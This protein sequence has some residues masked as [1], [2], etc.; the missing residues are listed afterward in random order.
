MYEYDFVSRSTGEHTLVIAR[1]YQE[2][3]Y[4]GNVDTVD[5]ELWYQEPFYEEDR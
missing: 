4:L 2:A 3:I 5:C 1:S